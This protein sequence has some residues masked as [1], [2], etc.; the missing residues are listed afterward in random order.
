MRDRKRTYSKH[1]DAEDP[2]LPDNKSRRTTPVYD[3]SNS[4][5]PLANF[6]GVGNT[7]STIDLSE[8]EDGE[9][10]WMKQQREATERMRLRKEVEADDAWFARQLQD[11][12]DGADLP[13][14]AYTPVDTFGAQTMQS[15]SNIPNWIQSRASLYP[16]SDEAMPSFLSPN[17]HRT[18]SASIPSHIKAEQPWS[19]PASHNEAHSWLGSS[20]VAGS[21]RMPGTFD[22]FDGLF[23]DESSAGNAV[24]GGFTDTESPAADSDLEIT[25]VVP[26]TSVHQALTNGSRPGTL[27]NGHAGILNNGSS[28]AGNSLSAIINRT[29]GY[30]FTTG[31]DYEGNPIPEESLNFLRDLELDNGLASGSSV[32]TD[33][34]QHLLA[35][36]PGDGGVDNQAETPEGF[37]HPLYLHQKIA[38]KWMQGMEADEKKRGGILAD[39]MGLG[40]TISTL[41]L[42][43]TRPATPL[44][45]SHYPH[46]SQICAL[47]EASFH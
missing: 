28:T 25:R 7:S 2:F 5:T 44:S 36:I 14:E 27:M 40:K 16:Q 42:V 26:F 22:S 45:G 20:S 23:G 17:T 21:S 47:D 34:I 19:F 38:L 10:F 32:T 33:D 31:L 12:F 15:G 30:N 1:L 24:Y 29:S 35:N 41:A 11:S 8:D 46:V 18:L 43:L 13:A 37:K 4:F 6:L 3:N 39:D 9:L